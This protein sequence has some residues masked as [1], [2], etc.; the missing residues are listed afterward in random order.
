MKVHANHTWNSSAY[1]NSV[2]INL[3][4]SEHLVYDTID[5]YIYQN[6]VAAYNPT[7]N[8][9]TL[10]VGIIKSSIQK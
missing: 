2:S 4:L 10:T 8:I 7:T 6:P 1:A 5:S 9:L 3:M